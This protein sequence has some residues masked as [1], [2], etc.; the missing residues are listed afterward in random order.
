MQCSFIA[1]DVGITSTPVID[2]ST[3][4]IFVVVRTLERSDGQELH[5]QRLHAL[6][7]LTGAERAG[8]PV[9]MALSCRMRRTVACVRSRVVPPAP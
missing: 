9:T 8:S 1:P 4:T 2:V 7:L 6:D 5:Y 3:R